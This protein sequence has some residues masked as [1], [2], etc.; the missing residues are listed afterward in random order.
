MWG[1]ASQPAV[2]EPP[3]NGGN[4]MPPTEPSQQSAPRPLQQAGRVGGAASDGEYEKR[5]VLEL[6]A[7]GGT[8]AV[9]PKDKLDDFLSSVRTLNIDVVGGIILDQLG[10]E[11]WQV[12]CHTHPTA[13]PPTERSPASHAL[14]HSEA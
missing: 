1:N 12:R 14:F 4:A 5:L 10:E 2:A 13:L 11:A 8:R 3:V 7:P 6:C 9:P